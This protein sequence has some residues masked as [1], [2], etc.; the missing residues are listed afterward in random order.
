MAT[1]GQ[2]S[3]G[4]SRNGNKYELADNASLYESEDYEEVLVGR[5]A[6]DYCLGMRVGLCQFEDWIADELSEDLLGDFSIYGYS[7]SGIGVHLENLNQAERAKYPK[8]MLAAST[9]YILCLACAK[10]AILM[11]YYALLNVM[12]FWKYV[13]YVVSGI[14]VAYTL[15][16]F[17]A[18]IF[19]CYPVERNWDPIPQFWDMDY[20]I[21]RTGLYLATALTNTTSDI[22]LILIPIPIIWRLH[23]PVGQKLGIAAIFGVGCMTIITSIARL[24]TIYPLVT[25]KDQP[26]EMGLASIL[27]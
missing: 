1:H 2:S 27:T 15:A 24:A 19:A 10:L 5:Y 8:S 17:F 23:V 20:C 16:I 25:S 4:R 6:Y 9:I 12:Q 22:I 3:R 11:F 26:Y 14:I 21:D 13:I 7:Y 18:L